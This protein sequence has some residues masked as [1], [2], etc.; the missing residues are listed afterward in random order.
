MNSSQIG[1]W[2]CIVAGSSSNCW[3]AA[4]VPEVH[5]R[6]VSRQKLPPS[7]NLAAT[8]KCVV[9]LARY[10]KTFA[11]VEQ[12]SSTA[13]SLKSHAD[14]KSQNESQTAEDSRSTLCKAIVLN[15]SSCIAKPTEH[16]VDLARDPVAFADDRNSGEFHYDSAPSQNLQPKCKAVVLN[17]SVTQISGRRRTAGGVANG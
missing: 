14:S 16:V 9:D 6:Q 15:R 4:S 2:V 10:P 8:P 17:C 13:P 3:W 7:C 1:H 11:G 12:L 5:Y